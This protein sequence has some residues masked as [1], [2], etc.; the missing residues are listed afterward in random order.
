MIFITMFCF[1][2][3]AHEN[4]I[5]S[6]LHRRS[7]CVLPSCLRLYSR[8]HWLRPISSDVIATMTTA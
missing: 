6:K 5:P 4:S 3:C 2:Y 1:S 8:L 7:P